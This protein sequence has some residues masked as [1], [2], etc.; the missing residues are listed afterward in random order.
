VAAQPT[1]CCYCCYRR[2]ADGEP[3][4]LIACTPCRI[5]VT[6]FCGL[7]LLLLSAEV[8]VGTLAAQV[9][10]K[11]NRVFEQN[12]T[13]CQLSAQQL[14]RGDIFC[15]PG[16]G[17][18][19][20]PHNMTRTMW[21][22]GCTSTYLIEEMEM[23]NSKQKWDLV[24][25]SSRAGTSGQ[26]S[27]QLD[28]W[29]L[30]VKDAKAPRIVVVHGNNANFNDWT[31]Q[32]SAY[33]LRSMGFAV[34]IP[35]LR[36]HGSSGMEGDGSKVTW[37]WSYHLDVLGA[38]DYLVNDPAGK[39]GGPM[40]SSKVGLQGYAIGGFASVVASGLEP[41][42]P[43]VFLDSPVFDP[44]DLLLFDLEKSLGLLAPGFGEAAWQV[45]KKLAG[46]D[47]GHHTIAEAVAARAPG[48]SSTLG[49]ASG[50]DCK[51]GYFNWEKGW[52]KTKKEACC[53]AFHVACPRCRMAVVAGS[54]DAGV[55]A[56]Q[57]DK[58]VDLLRSDPASS[59]Y[60]VTLHLQI[61]E[62]CGAADHLSLAAWGPDLYRQRL[63]DFWAPTFGLSVRSCG[64]AELPHFAMD[65]G[66]TKGWTDKPMGPLFG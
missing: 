25:F 3:T 22:P 9:F 15:S 36:S 38:W 18:T 56:S 61:D 26:E 46:V 19:R 7:L 4:W 35:N 57:A 48:S 39:L 13:S 20:A 30:P 55:P 44:K 49:K 65:V 59:S 33:M 64:L 23:F 50:F 11:N 51:A 60:D 17:S 54:N 66:A 12:L 6:G 28:A 43:G 42:I 62:R 37:G 24:T 27:V 52:A 58:L 1:V 5:C 31:V 47:L 21:F 53:K 8:A 41:S 14:A 10:V 2:G 32:L 40:A 16:S 34:L 29:W 63:C 45:A